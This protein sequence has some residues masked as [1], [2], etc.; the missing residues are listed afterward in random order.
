MPPPHHICY[1]LKFSALMVSFRNS[2]EDRRLDHR[3]STE[4]KGLQS[5]PEDFIQ[6]KEL[7]Q[8]FPGWWRQKEAWRA[9]GVKTAGATF[10][11]N[12]YYCPASLLE[13]HHQGVDV[14]FPTG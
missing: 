1:S 5:N 8:D 6:G 10:D 13:N 9:F 7:P 11:H 14:V 12:G 2:L 3:S 4:I